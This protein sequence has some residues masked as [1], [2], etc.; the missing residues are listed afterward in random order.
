MT[1]EGIDVAHYQSSTYSTAEL[2]FVMVKASEG[3]SYVNPRHAAQIAHGRAN[4]LVVGH[5]HFAR[6]GS[7]TAQADY[8]LAHASAQ[9]GDVL[10]FDWEDT[11]VSGADKDAWLHRVQA[12]APG[13][14]VILY[15][16]RDFWLHRD[17]TSYAADGL[18]IA[19]PSAPKGH[20][21][22]EHP[23]LFHQ[24]GSPGGMD[25]NV[26]NFA[27]AGALA[28]WAGKAA[29]KPP[30][31]AKPAKPKVDLSNLIAAAKTDPKSRQGHQTHA[32]DVRIVEA[33]LK[34]AGY[35]PAAYA[36]DGSFGTVTVAAYAKWQRHLGYTGHDADGIPGKASLTK[37]GAQHGFTVV[38]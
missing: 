26:G 1:V 15:C 35:L 6:P 8:F 4:G 9:P 11:G 37:L 27:S 34:A 33:A 10:A 36:G 12:K 23:W 17:T 13:H 25:R 19:D 21:R 5:Y 28:T 20:P 38:A 31:P 32:A 22:V 30:A 29:P 16:N 3:S 14:R 2:D 7:M 24:Y 18:W